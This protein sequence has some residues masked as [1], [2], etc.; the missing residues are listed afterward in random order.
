[1]PDSKSSGVDA[2]DELLQEVRSSISD[3]LRRAMRVAA[4]SDTGGIRR[5][6]QKELATCSGVARSSISNYLS[7]NQL[8]NPDLSSLCRIASALNIPPAFLL[9]RREDWKRMIEVAYTLNPTLKDPSIQ[10][11]VTEGND[12]PERRA[13]MALKIVERMGLGPAHQADESSHE[14][15]SSMTSIRRRQLLGIVAT[16]A[17]PPLQQGTPAVLAALLCFCAAIGANSI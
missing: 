5:I 1:M 4:S 16:C 14:A 2:G 10:I 13:E 7:G 8:S 9:M 11:L 12:S 6:S 17:L 3:S 15:A